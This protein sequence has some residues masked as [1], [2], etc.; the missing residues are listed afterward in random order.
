MLK[1][2]ANAE[3]GLN[4]FF[5]LLK[6]SP[7]TMDER[8]IL[9]YPRQNIGLATSILHVRRFAVEDNSL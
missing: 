1:D 5:N 7:A 2:M 4:I 8:K 3:R 6:S 9:I